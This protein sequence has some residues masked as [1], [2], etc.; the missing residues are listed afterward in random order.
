MWIKVVELESELGKQKELRAMYKMRMERTQDYL[1]YCLQ[2]AQDKGFLDIILNNN[3]NKDINID[4]ATTDLPTPPPPPVHH[5]SD[6]L[7]VID[8][9]KMNGWYIEPNE[10]RLGFSITSKK[11][12]NLDTHVFVALIIIVFNR[13]LKYFLEF[14]YLKYDLHIL[15][16]N[17]NPY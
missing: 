8:Q 1:R 5:H 15:L 10:V 12:S 9:A 4:G 2:I 6:L 7:A 14:I 17:I 3:N 11:L 13:K 16:V